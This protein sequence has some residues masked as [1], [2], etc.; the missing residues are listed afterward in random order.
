MLFRSKTKEYNNQIDD[1]LNILEDIEEFIIHSRNSIDLTKQHLKDKNLY[2]I[3]KKIYN[4]ATLLSQNSRDN[5]GVNG[6]MLLLIEKMSDGNFS[7]KISL[8]SDDP[9]LNYFAKNLNIVSNKLH[10]NFIEIVNILKEYK[11]GSYIKTLNDK[12]FRDGEIKSCIKGINSL[13]NSFSS[14]LHDNYKYGH[15]LKDNSKALNEKMDDVKV[16]SKKQSKILEDVSSSIDKFIQNTKSNTDNTQD[17]QNSSIKIESSVKEGL[18]YANKTVGAMEDI[19]SSTNAINEAIDIIDKIAFQTNILSLNAAVEAATAGEAGKGF[20]VVASEV[21][22]LASRSAEAAKSIKDLV[23][24]ATVKANEG[25]DITDKM[26][27]GYNELNVNIENTISFIDKS[28]LLA[29]EQLEDIDQMNSAVELLQSSTKS[30]DHMTLQTNEIA[31]EVE[32]ISD[33]ILSVTEKTEFEGKNM[34]LEEIE[35]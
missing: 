21:R 35:V 4:I 2:K 3:Y 18:S 12:E 16:A 15:E 17:M 32:A 30:Y 7:D 14:I 29:K 11:S 28:T 23:V 10:N 6:E 25:K 27:K 33:K 13:K 20:A 19:N 31:K 8:K 22:N 9:Y 26:I 5:L 24:E 34:V 1:I